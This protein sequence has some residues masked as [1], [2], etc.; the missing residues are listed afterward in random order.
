MHCSNHSLD[1]NLLQ[2]RTINCS[3]SLQRYTKQLP[4]QSIRVAISCGV[5][6]FG[7]TTPYFFGVNNHAIT[8]EPE[9]YCNTLQTFLATQVQI[10]RQWVRNVWFKQDAPTWQGKHYFSLGNMNFFTRARPLLSPGSTAA[11]RLIVHK[12]EL[13]IWQLNWP[14]QWLDLTAPDLPPWEC[15]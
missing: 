12:H 2:L 5:Y 4:L 8:V 6:L 7:V 9:F 1:C 3:S 11:L 15:L 13:T 10:I 14:S